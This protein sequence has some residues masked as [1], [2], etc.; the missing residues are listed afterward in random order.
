[1]GEAEEYLLGGTEDEAKEE[2]Q[3]RWDVSKVTV[4]VVL[5]LAVAS[6][7]VFVGRPQAE[8][9]RLASLPGRLRLRR[10]YAQNVLCYEAEVEGVEDVEFAYRPIGSTQWTWSRTK[11]LC[12][13]RLKSA[14]EVRA[15]RGSELVA[16]TELM[17]EGIGIT[18]LDDEQPFGTVLSGRSSFPLV[19]VQHIVGSM[20]ETAWVGLLTLDREGYIVW[21]HE[22]NTSS[23]SYAVFDQ[24]DDFNVAVMVEMTTVAPN[25]ELQVIDPVSNDA[26]VSI[27]QEHCDNT[28]YAQYSHEA[29]VV[30]S[31]EM[32]TF[33]Y[34]NRKDYGDYRSLEPLSSQMAE[35][36]LQRQG[37][38][39]PVEYVGDKLVRWDMVSRRT[40]DVY[41]IFDFLNPLD[42]VLQG[43]TYGWLDTRCAVDTR[44]GVEWSHAS[45][46]AL[47]A[48][49][50]Y[51][52]TLRNLHMVLAIRRDGSSVKWGLASDEAVWSGDEP[53]PVYRI[54][55]EAAKFWEPHAVSPGR[56]PLDFFLVD[57][58][59]SR[60]GCTGSPT[61]C[62]SRAVGY[63]L[64]PGTLTAHL[65]FEFEFPV[66][67]G[68]P[69]E[70]DLDLYNSNGGYVA[71]LPDDGVVVALTS[72]S[73]DD[74]PNVG[75]PAFVFDVAPNATIRSELR[76][77]RVPRSHKSGSY[78]AIPAFSVAGERDLPPDR[79]A[80]FF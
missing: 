50:D 48:D 16:S 27:P 31:S 26:L 7:S 2:R 61:T 62:F 64:D 33:S 12:R 39:T 59:T 37:N 8:V 51:L 54:E 63:R 30:S 4:L 17:T 44:Q 76:L 13:L 80:A 21:Y 72:V 57:D 29:K 10:P 49:N 68:A 70:V 45:S 23:T 36:W 67:A 78:R 1:M 20:D 6:M 55:S 32:V 14:H 3:S 40:E 65:A 24:R 56:S 77:P 41:E 66:P 9:A 5:V 34:I 43:S 58:G 75:H 79:A 74:D 52:V 11:T 28:T 15:Y 38:E 69:G 73:I 53:F 18:E 46:A 22:F 19:T 47:D 42:N 25:S 35:D 60:P 71:R